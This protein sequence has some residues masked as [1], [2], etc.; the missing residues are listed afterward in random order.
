MNRLIAG[1]VAVVVIAY[2]LFSSIYIVHVRQQAIVLRFGKIIDDADRARALLQAAD[3]AGRLRADHRQPAAALRHLQPASCRSATAP[4]TSSTRSS[5]TDRRPGEVPRAAAG[6][7]RSGR[8]EHPRRASIRRCGQVYGKRAFTAALSAERAAMMREVR[9]LIAPQMVDLGIEVTDVR[10]LSTDLHARCVEE[11]LRAHVGGAL[12]AGGGDPRRRHAGGGLDPRHRQ[13][14]VDR[15]R[16]RRQQGQRNPARRGRRAARRRS[17]PQAYGADPEFFE[18]YRALQSYRTAL[19]LEQHDDGAVARQRVLP[20][21]QGRHARRQ[22]ADSGD[23]ER[24]FRCRP[25][26]ELTSARAARRAA[27]AQCRR[28]TDTTRALCRARRARH[29]GRARPRQSA[30]GAARRRRSTQAQ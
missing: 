4:S 17:T 22:G 15:D 1:G 23:A 28:A 30:A 10:I 26:T 14:A 24:A 18:F 7:P 5:P 2:L 8:A 12:C 3:V 19:G 6:R 25:S 13:P 11:H 9:D 27:A 16:R 21:L 20:V 29:A